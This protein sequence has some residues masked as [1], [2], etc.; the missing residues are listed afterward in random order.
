MELSINQKSNNELSINQKSN[1]K[2]K[3]AIGIF[4]VLTLISGVLIGKFYF[5]NQ[6]QSNNFTTISDKQESQ[7]KISDD[8]QTAITRAIGKVE[9]AIVGFNV[10]EV[11]EVRNPFFDDPFFRQ[12]FGNQGNR[13]QVVR[14]LGS[15]F[16]ISPDGY[17][18]TNDHV[19]GNATK[20]SVTLTTGETVQAQLIGND[21][22]TDIALLKI[23]KSNLPYIPF[24]NSDNILIGEWVIALGNPFG[25]FEIND[26]PTV[27]VGVV[28]ATDM[29]VSSVLQI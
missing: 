7:Q 4:A 10:E 14:G 21:P 3:L 19:A 9:N 24:G 29:K 18:I 2:T 17:I 6:P 20:I 23:D 5:G 22:T 16:I 28:S 25:L 11:R 26:K 12:F 8:R 1:N 13:K 27:T 15:G